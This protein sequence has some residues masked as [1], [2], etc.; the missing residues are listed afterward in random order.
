MSNFLAKNISIVVSSSDGYDDCWDPFFTLLKNYFPGIDQIEILLSTQTKDYSNPFSKLKVVK[1][2]PK[3]A[4]SQRLMQTLD[5]A[6]NEIILFLDEDSFI[7]KPANVNLLKDLVELMVA[8]NEID[9]IRLTKGDWE[10]TPANEF[11]LIEKLT[12]GSKKRFMMH[13]GIWRKDVLKKH[14][15]VPFLP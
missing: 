1:H 6:S 2:G 14:L 13:A 4:W 3:A 9:H 7:R 10:T 12:P 15:A 11:E 8:N 5:Q